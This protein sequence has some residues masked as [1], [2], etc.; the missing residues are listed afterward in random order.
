MGNLSK[1]EIIKR[2]GM[3]PDL[4]E[5]RGQC[6]DVGNGNSRV[7]AL[8]QQPTRF[9]FTLKP[10][11]GKGKAN[12]GPAAF[13]LLKRHAPSLYMQL[14][15]GRHWLQ[16]MVEAEKASIRSTSF[17]RRVIDTRDKMVAVRQIARKRLADYRALRPHGVLPAALQ[18]L[19]TLLDRKPP[20]FMNDETA[21]LWFENAIL[22]LEQEL[23]RT[24][25]VEKPAP[26]PVARASSFAPVPEIHF[27][28]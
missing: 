27:C 20:A 23:L 1:A 12:I 8:T 2:L 18:P 24:A 6:Y 19:R 7:C 28:D 16:L 4:W 17:R 3:A 26:V 13:Y 25:H 15:R 14:E 21:R 5:F 22:D 10:K 11:V 9:C